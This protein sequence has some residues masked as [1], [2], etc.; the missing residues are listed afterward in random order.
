MSKSY[1]IG[2]NRLIVDNEY[3]GVL[4]FSLR[5]SAG[6]W[7]QWKLNSDENSIEF[8]TGDKIKIDKTS[9]EV[10]INLGPS[11]LILGADIPSPDDEDNFIQEKLIEEVPNTWAVWEI[12]NNLLL[13]LNERM[14]V[15][16]QRLSVVESAL[17]IVPE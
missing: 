12:I 16:E 15:F 14:D 6:N 9:K 3:D 2:K 13:P 11:K 1:Q 8:P 17:G 4:K 10:L 5:D 7:T